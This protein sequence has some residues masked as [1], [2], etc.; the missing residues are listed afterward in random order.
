MEGI[1]TRKLIIGIDEVGTGA[2]AGPL[3]VCACYVPPEHWQTLK[4]WGFTDSKKL[5]EE[6]REYLAKKLKEEGPALGVAWAYGIV[7]PIY[8]DKLTPLDAQNKAARTALLLLMRKLDCEFEDIA[9]ILD[10]NNLLP[11][12][13]KTVTQ[14]ALP[15]ADLHYLPVSVASVM[16]KT[17]RDGE[18]RL[19]HDQYPL[20][21]FKRNKGYPTLEHLT[22]LVKVGP[23][24]GIHRRHYLKNTIRK[25]YD[26][27]LKG[28]IKLPDW[29]E[30][31]KWLS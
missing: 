22:A 27:Y 8:I 11:N 29:I 15:K 30:Q 26:T 2:I 21:N 17:L 1:N 14:V 24:Y 7:D 9:I 6:K 23:M 31:D 16:A 10:G 18:M 19:L 20:F 5:R 3:V 4:E 25:H 12:V 28:H 13:P